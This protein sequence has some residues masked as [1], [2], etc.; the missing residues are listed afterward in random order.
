MKPTFLEYVFHSFE[1]LIILILQKILENN[2]KTI[3]K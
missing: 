3:K 2:I 1:V